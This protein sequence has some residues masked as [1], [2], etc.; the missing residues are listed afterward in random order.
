MNL[1]GITLLNRDE[2]K[3]DK[4][5]LATGTS[6]LLPIRSSG[7]L[8]SK[9]LPVTPTHA[10]ITNDDVQFSFSVRSQNTLRQLQR[11]NADLARERDEAIE[12]A[13]ALHNQQQDMYDN[14]KLLRE[15][16]DDLKTELHHVLWEFIPTQQVGEISGFSELGQVNHAIYETPDRI[17]SYIIGSLLGE[18]QFSDV[19][20]CTHYDSGNRYAIKII[21]K[22][23]IST[24]YGLKR[25]R[26]EIGL[27]RQLHHPNIVTF[28]DYIH[29][30]TCLYL[31]TD[32]GG[33]DLFEFFEANPFGADENTAK[34]IILGIVRPLNYLHNSGICHLDLKPENILLSVEGQG[35]SYNNVRICDF[36]Q[37]VIATSH[38]C[39]K[40]TGLCGSPGFFAPEM[41]I[42]EDSTY[43]GFAADVWSVGCVMLELIM[44]HDEFCRVWMTSYD[45]D[46]LQDD[47][48]FEKVLGQAVVN[49]AKCQ[50][51]TIKEDMNNFMKQLLV[52]EPSLRLTASDMMGDRWLPEVAKV[53]ETNA[54]GEQKRDQK[55]NK[56][57]P[58]TSKDAPSQS[59]VSRDKQ[60]FFRNSFSSRARKHF[61]GV[62][63]RGDKVVLND[64]PSINTSVDRNDS[65]QHIEI[66][67]P[68]IEPGTPSCKAARKVIVEGGKIIQ[69]IEASGPLGFD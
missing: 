13:R 35:I 23:K 22:Q 9:L 17:G 39:M 68:P 43:N 12:S 55:E 54:G 48:K 14:F 25:V 53:T 60:S 8:R 11:Q 50:N 46:I 59:A 24:M 5:D 41:V 45:Y 18:G 42:G 69:T 38:E 31:M 19:K 34:Q 6:P 33:K 47:T 37:S 3:N 52:I 26:N 16:Y 20:L 58:N 40:L 30:P 21:Q 36:G 10:L 67:L 15:K 4:N 65:S 44:G 49:L 51:L 1:N 29:S 2:M 62:N 61:A 63:E 57:A 7:E 32:I 56:L 66:K 28:V 27:L 64:D